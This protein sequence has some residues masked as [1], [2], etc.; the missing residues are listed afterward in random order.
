MFAGTSITDF[1]VIDRLFLSRFQAPSPVCQSIK[2]LS[3][4]RGRKPLSQVTEVL[5]GLP[6]MLA[7]PPPTTER[8]LPESPESL[9]ANR[10]PPS[11][12]CDCSFCDRP[13]GHLVCQSCGYAFNG[14]VR[15]DCPRHPAIIHLMDCE[16]CPQ[17]LGDQMRE[18]KMAK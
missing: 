18:Y 4:A 1:T 11:L 12:P 5:Q 10:Q 14:R 2:F 16:F 15:M 17:C 13:A 9:E 3:L 8:V 7:I 6:R